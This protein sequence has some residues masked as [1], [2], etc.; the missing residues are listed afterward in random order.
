MN[1]KKLHL[2]NHTSDYHEQLIN[3]LKNKKEATLYLQVALE[4]YGEDGNTEAFMV[5]LRNIAEAQGGINTLAKKTALN[6][7]NL[8]RIL[9]SKGNPRFSTLGN[10]IRALGFRLSIA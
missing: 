3:L 9:T 7:Q 1:R 8:Y 5:A 4:E 10:I 2:L 6:R